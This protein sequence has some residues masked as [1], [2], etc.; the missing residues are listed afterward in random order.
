MTVLTNPTIIPSFTLQVTLG[1]NQHALLI[2]F[3]N[4][5]T[6]SGTLDAQ[7]PDFVWNIA[8]RKF[9]F[10]TFGDRLDDQNFYPLVVAGT[11]QASNGSIPVNSATAPVNVQDLGGPL[12]FDAGVDQRSDAERLV[13]RSRR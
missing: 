13:F 12:V 3:D 10:R 6:G 4:F 1:S 8:E 2:D 9:L 5:A 11:F 7:N